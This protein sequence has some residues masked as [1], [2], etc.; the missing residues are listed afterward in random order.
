MT[1]TSVV[2]PDGVLSAS[3]P[4]RCSKPPGAHTRRYKELTVRN[5]KTTLK[6]QELLAE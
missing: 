6:L 3:G 1:K 2:G 5:L 4:N